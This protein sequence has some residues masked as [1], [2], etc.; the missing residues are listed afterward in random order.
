MLIVMKIIFKM[1]VGNSDFDEIW[2][3]IVSDNAYCCTH[4]HIHI[5]I[6]T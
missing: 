3:V 5:L 2:I 4:T 1:F 6:Y